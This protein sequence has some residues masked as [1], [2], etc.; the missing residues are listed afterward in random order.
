MASRASVSFSFGCAAVTA[1]TLVWMACGSSTPSGGVPAGDAAPPPSGSSSGGTGAN[2]GSSGAGGSGSS[3]GGS[4]GAGTGSSS[5]GGTGSS[6][7]GGAGS[8]SGS[9]SGGSS[10]GSMGTCPGVPCTGGLTCCAESATGSTSCVASCSSSDV[11]QCTVPS[12]CAGSD[13]GT[14]C[15]GTAVLADNPD[16][17]AFPYCS[18]T[19]ITGYCATTCPF[20]LGATCTST[21]KLQVCSSPADCAGNSSATECCTLSGYSACVSSVVAGLGGLT[22]M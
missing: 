20:S 13:A 11:V 3:G 17:A 1:C 16:G 8:S 7:G 22:C 10:S 2:G 15:C 12:E 5:G 21:E 6:S 19:S 9:S 4:S 18:I 14:A